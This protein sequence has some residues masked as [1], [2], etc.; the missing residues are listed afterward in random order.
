MGMFDISPAAM[1]GYDFVTNDFIP[2]TQSTSPY[3]QSVE[4]ASNAGFDPWTAF[5]NAGSQIGTKLLS[6]WAD[7]QLNKWQA[8]NAIRASSDT[9]AQPAAAG[10][11]LLNSNVVTVG[12]LGVGA[13]AL[14]MLLKD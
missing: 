10:A 12:L 6:G 14:F 9:P 13:V 7:T 4:Q 2:V 11:G 8:E 5:V 1:V 3:Q